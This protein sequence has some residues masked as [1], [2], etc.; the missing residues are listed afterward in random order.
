LVTLA[1]D[2]A[3]KQLID[4]TASSQTITH[5]LKMGSEREKL[6]RQRLMRENEVLSAKVDAMESGRRVEE[7]YSQALEAMRN[8]GGLPSAEESDYDDEML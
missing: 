3:E 6:E 7:L 4:G 5:F 1:I 2:L 8:Y